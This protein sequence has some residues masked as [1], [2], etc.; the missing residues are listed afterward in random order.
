MIKETGKVVAVDNEFV[1]LETINRGTCGSC[2]AEKGCGQSLLARWMSR[3]HYLKVSLDG[4]DPKQF[5]INDHVDIGVPEN[6]VVVSSLLV[7]CLPLI[8]MILGAGLG[9]SEFGSDSAAAAGAL[10]GLALGAALV[11]TYTWLERGNRRL[12]PVIMELVENTIET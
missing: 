12:R 4:R 9:Q 10:L 8:G 7:Y 1:W 6:V 2:A 5:S 3:S 11:R